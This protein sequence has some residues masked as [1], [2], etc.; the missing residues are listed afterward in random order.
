MISEALRCSI[1]NREP[2]AA[3]SSVMTYDWLDFVIRS[4][5]PTKLCLL[6]PLRVAGPEY[7][8]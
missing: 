1:P 3:F 2:R 5:P 6:H 8:R 7:F 4:F